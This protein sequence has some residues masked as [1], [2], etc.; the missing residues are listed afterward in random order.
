MQRSTFKVLFYVK[1]QSE[2]SGQVP[3]M[4]RI[5]IN[6]TMSQFSCK[7]T[8][9]STLWDA[10]ANKASG[11]SLEAQRLNE[12][13][14]N[15]KTNIGKQYQRLCDRDSYVTAER[16]RNAFLGMGDDCRLLL[17]TFDEYLAGFLKRVGKDRAYSSY[18]DYCKR[19]RRLA[20]FLEYEYHVKD[21]A[22]KELKRDFIEKFVVYLSSIQGMRSGTIH[23]TVKK[24]KLM[25]YTAYKNGWIAVDP[26]AGFHVRPKYA[27]RRYLSA[28]ELQA[29][30][31]VKLPNY[32]TGINRDVFVFCAFTGLR[33]AEVVKLTHADIHTDDNGE[34]WIIDKRQKTGM[35]FRVK[36]LPVAEMLYE[37]YKDMHLAGDKVFPLKGTHKT[38]NMSLRQVARHAG[39]SFNPT[40]HMARHTFATTV[41]LT[42]G[43]PLETVSKMLGHKHITTTQ[44]YAKITNDKI[45]QDM[46][47][48]SEKL[49]SVFKVAQ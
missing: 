15:I 39:L 32:R 31:D 42:Q 11:K 30:M 23:S 25:T 41:T 4:G 27:E 21:I 16:V 5:T 22:F 10:K 17:Q 34:R 6:G 9:R 12:K 36:L 44:I 45:G 2:K 7:L 28:S 49:S 8:V 46:A 33:H 14:E 48:L 47:A 20:S 24:L 43:V 40:I 3:V 19:R 18:K 37:R 35:Q 13:L 26:F 38:L 1:R 29:V